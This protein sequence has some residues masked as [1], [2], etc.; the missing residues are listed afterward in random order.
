MR[1]VDPKSW[2]PARAQ[3]I[4]QLAL[5]LEFELRTALGEGDA[6]SR[7][8]CD[9]AYRALRLSLI[10]YGQPH[11]PSPADVLG[12]LLGALAET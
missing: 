8:L 1:A 6:E 5:E 12:R 3:R 2:E 11:E 7:K 9:E 4:R 10:P